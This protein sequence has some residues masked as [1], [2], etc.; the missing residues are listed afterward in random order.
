[1]IPKIILVIAAGVWLILTSPHIIYSIVLIAIL[2]GMFWL[3][4]HVFNFFSEDD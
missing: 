2:L 3:D 4:K 1:M